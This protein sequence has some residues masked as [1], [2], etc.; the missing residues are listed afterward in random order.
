[1]TWK[2]AWLPHSFGANRGQSRTSPLSPFGSLCATQ[3]YRDGKHRGLSSSRRGSVSCQASAPLARAAVALHLVADARGLFVATFRS[4]HSGGLPVL[5]AKGRMQPARAA[6][7]FSPRAAARVFSPAANFLGRA[8]ALR[9]RTPLK[10]D[11]RI[12]SA[13]ARRSEVA[14]EGHAGVAWGSR[15]RRPLRRAQ[16]NEMEFA[17]LASRASS[18]LRL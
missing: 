6:F 9:H 4:E 5:S 17:W 2:D 11:T 1:M 10:Q 15:R 18:E 16:F 3:S 7:G 12:S 13:T 14:V 8:E